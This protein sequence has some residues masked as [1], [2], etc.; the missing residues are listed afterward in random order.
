MARIGLTG[1]KEKTDTEKLQDM[2]LKIFQDQAPEDLIEIENILL[3]L[4]SM[5]A[6]Y[7][8]KKLALEI[9][10][11]LIVAVEQAED[12]AETAREVIR[13]LE[14]KNAGLLLRSNKIMFMNLYDLGLPKK[15]GE[16]LWHT[17][18]IATLKDIILNTE[19]ELIK[20]TGIGKKSLQEII[21]FL[22]K[23]GLKLQDS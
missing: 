15:I 1:K 11:C 20:I 7:F 18:H 16:I 12:E 4:K 17:K 5:K 14:E 9:F 6:K 19:N 10:K 23:L 21:T 8:S 22:A 3:F 13:D 2:Y